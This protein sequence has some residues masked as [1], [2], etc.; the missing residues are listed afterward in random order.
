M[1]KLEYSR[2]NAKIKYEWVDNSTKVCDLVIILT[3]LMK[4]LLSFVCCRFQV[5]GEITMDE[6]IRSSKSLSLGMP[7]APQ[8]NIQGLPSN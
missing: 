6:G 2:Y 5:L 8:G 4:V 7:E 3:D 1:E